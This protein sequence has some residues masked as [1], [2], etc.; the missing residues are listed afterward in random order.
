MRGKCH[1]ENKELDWLDRFMVV[2]AT[3]GRGIRKDLEKTFIPRFEG[4]EEVSHAEI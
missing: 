3:L 4:W 1:K 2:K